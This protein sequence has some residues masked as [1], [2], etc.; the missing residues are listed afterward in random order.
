MT[1]KNLPSAA[2]LNMLHSN[3]CIV[4]SAKNEREQVSPIFKA[5]PAKKKILF[6]P[7]SKG[8]HGSRA[9]W[10]EW[11]DNDVYWVAVNG[12]LKEYVPAVPPAD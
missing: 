6:T 8:Q 4:T 10:N 11:S 5:S 9:L 1:V 12:F 2:C 3:C 7:A